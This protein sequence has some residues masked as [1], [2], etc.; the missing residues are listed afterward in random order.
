MRQITLIGFPQ[1]SLEQKFSWLHQQLREVE[2]ASRENDAVLLANNFVITGAY[3]P[4][5][6]IDATAATL[7]EVREFLATFIDDLK[8]GGSTRTT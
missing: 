2:T 5:R 3:T 4:R 8:R 1:G 7:T 6:T